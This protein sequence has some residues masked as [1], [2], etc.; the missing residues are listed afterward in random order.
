MWTF[1]TPQGPRRERVRG[2]LRIDDGAALCDATIA[3]LGLSTMSTWVSA[4]AIHQ[5]ALVVVLPEFPLVSAHAIW[6]LYPSSRLLSPKVRVM[7]DHLAARF[8]PTP[9][10]DEPPKTSD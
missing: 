10:W 3:G 6:A 4:Q 7:I 1:K 9:Y 2:R 8:G 5:G